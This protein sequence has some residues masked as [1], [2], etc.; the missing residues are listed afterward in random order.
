MTVEEHPRSIGGWLIRVTI[1]L[2]AFWRAISSNS[3]KA[4]NAGPGMTM[5]NEELRLMKEVRR[6]LVRCHSS[7]FRQTWPR[8]FVMGLMTLALLASCTR[9]PEQMLPGHD[10]AERRI[11]TYERGKARACPL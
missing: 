10:N 3:G 6:V 2:I 4:A 5:L 11:K 7:Y 8:I 1:G 9:A